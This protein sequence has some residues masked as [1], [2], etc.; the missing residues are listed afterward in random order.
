MSII[1]KSDVGAGDEGRGRS[2]IS[3]NSSPRSEVVRNGE[4]RVV[5]N[6]REKRGSDTTGGGGATG[7]GGRAS[8][9]IY[10]LANGKAEDEAVRW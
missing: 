4:P 5:E 9:N 6:K 7:V 2:L 10:V 8:L 1:E 3:S